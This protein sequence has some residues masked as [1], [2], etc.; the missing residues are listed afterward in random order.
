MVEFIRTAREPEN[1]ADDN[2]RMVIVSA[3][4]N[5]LTCWTDIDRDANHDLELVRFR[6]DSENRTL[7][8]DTSDA[9]RPD[10]L[11]W[12]EYPPCR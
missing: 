1:V 6:V 7:Y 3:D 10:L 8:R 12:Y 9:G 2:L 11:R 4:S 5:S